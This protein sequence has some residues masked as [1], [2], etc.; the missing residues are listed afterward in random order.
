MMRSRLAWFVKGMPNSSQFRK[1]ITQISTEKEALELIERY[2]ES[3]VQESDT[4]KM[5]GR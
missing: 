1:S 4:I 2:E 5:A 3:L